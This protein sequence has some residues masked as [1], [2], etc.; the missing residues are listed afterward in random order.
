[1]PIAP[2]PCPTWNKSIYDEC[3]SRGYLISGNPVEVVENCKIRACPP[4]RTVSTPL[5]P[6]KQ[7]S[8]P[9]PGRPP[10]P[11][12]P[13]STLPPQNIDPAS[14]CRIF[15]QALFNKCV[16]NS[17]TKAEDC[18]S[19]ACEGRTIGSPIPTWAIQNMADQVKYDYIAAGEAEC[20]AT[21]NK[22]KTAAN[23]ALLAA[24]VGAG[25]LAWKMTP[26]GG[27]LKTL[28]AA[29]AFGLIA[30]TYYTLSITGSGA[31]RI[32]PCNDDDKRAK[33]APPSFQY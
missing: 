20:A 31:Q 8:L 33:F 11:T 13:A 27:G 18:F 32:H 28:A 12:A 22:V 30:S 15:N 21:Q 26:Y 16:L 3:I 9:T 10:S 5:T 7:A 29:T 24:S 25:A 6:P 4:A 14:Q 19:L 2:P 23:I 17:Q 1:M